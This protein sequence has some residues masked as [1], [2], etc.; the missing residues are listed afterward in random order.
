MTL[1]GQI[2]GPKEL[3]RFIDCLLAHPH[4]TKDELARVCGSARELGLGGI[5]V[6]TSRVAQA[7]HLLE[8][9]GVKVIA[10][11]GF[12]FGGAD[13]DAKRYE[14]EVAIDHDAH[15]IEAVANIG[16]IKDADHAYVSREF[17][18]L[19]EAADER[20]VSI[21]IEA[22]LLTRAEIEAV[23][24]LAIE[25]GCKGIT[26]STGLEGRVARIEDVQ[27]IREIVGEKFGIRAVGGIADGAAALAMLEAGATRI[28][29]SGGREV[30]DSLEAQGR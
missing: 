24:Q 17:R 7:G 29:L 1:P 20:P 14:T 4:V 5:C 22:P 28:G 15:F 12:P 16:R 13:A 30:L 8:H 10:V 9:S 23:C 27:L 6:P 2:S 3:A 18:D 11:I 19:V 21:V 25:A 26:T